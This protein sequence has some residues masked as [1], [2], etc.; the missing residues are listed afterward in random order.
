MLFLTTGGLKA[1]PLVIGKVTTVV[2]MITV[3]MV[4]LSAPGP[5][6]TVF[7]VATVALTFISG[8]GYLRVGSRLFP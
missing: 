6:Q 4:L 7:F 8:L 1:Q 5:A 3:L 2:Q